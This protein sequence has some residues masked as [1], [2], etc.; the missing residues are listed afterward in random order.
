[1]FG[2]NKE[3]TKYQ[4]LILKKKDRMGGNPIRSFSD[5]LTFLKRDANI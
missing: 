1:L 5:K 3:K 4:N 2:N